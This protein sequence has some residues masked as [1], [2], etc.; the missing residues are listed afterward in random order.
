MPHDHTDTI[1]QVTSEVLEQLAFV[2][3]D[4]AT[5][6]ELP[7][8]LSDAYAVSVGFRGDATGTLTVVTGHEICAEL[9]ANITGE[10]AEEVST[11]TGQLA[12]S[13][14]ANVLCGHALTEI[15]GN[16]PVI[17]LDPPQ[18]IDDADR[19]WQAL[20]SSTSSVALLAD[21]CPVVLQLDLK[22]DNAKAA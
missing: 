4:P 17:D 19:I 11:E 12:L 2:F 6:D 8:T 7:E 22:L 14:L 15:V 10:D 13:E 18:P 5:T 16:E 20:R 9:A 1:T 21:D 3:A